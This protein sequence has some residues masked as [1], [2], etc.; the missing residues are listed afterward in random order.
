MSNHLVKCRRNV[1]SKEFHVKKGL[2]LARTCSIPFSMF[3][4]IYIMLFFN[5]KFAEETLYTDVWT[6]GIV[7]LRLKFSE[8]SSDRFMPSKTWLHKRSWKQNLGDLWR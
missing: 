4:D 1:H 7:T 3:P 5:L 6:I 2:T 8:V